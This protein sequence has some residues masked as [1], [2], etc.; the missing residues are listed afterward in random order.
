[1][2]TFAT[3]AALLLIAG[4]AAAQATASVVTNGSAIIMDPASIQPGAALSVDPVAAPKAGSRTAKA[5]AGSFTLSGQG[6][7]TFNLAVPA[8]VKLVR[9]GGSE[10]I[11]LKL[12]SK[13]AMGAFQGQEGRISEA[14]VGVAGSATVTSTAKGGVYKGEVPVTLTYQ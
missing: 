8:S 7:E 6:G 1:M 2:R 12:D 14:E 11:E 3:A 10:E 5:N 13:G 9:E 4:P